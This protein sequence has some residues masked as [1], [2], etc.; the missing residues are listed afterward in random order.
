[1]TMVAKVGMKFP[2]RVFMTELRRQEIELCVLRAR[3][4]RLEFDKTE[5]KRALNSLKKKVKR[6]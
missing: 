4:A 3:C 2:G 6:S 1:M 5:L